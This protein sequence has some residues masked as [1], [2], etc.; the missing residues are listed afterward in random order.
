MFGNEARRAVNTAAERG[1]SRPPSPIA[2]VPRAP[3]ARRKLRLMDN[4]P[5][6]T[7]RDNFLGDGVPVRCTLRDKGKS[8]VRLSVV[9][10]L[11]LAAAPLRA[12]TVYRCVEKGKPVSF[13]S[14]PCDEKA[15]ATAPSATSRT[16][17]RH[18][19]RVASRRHAERNGPALRPGASG[20]GARGGSHASQCR[21]RD[22]LAGAQRA[23]RMGT[24]LPVGTQRR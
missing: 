3:Q 2:A 18:R 12:G 6:S 13:Q 19:R 14:E 20:D 15:R 21:R 24:P 7:P 8:M 1:R 4:A 9:A 16:P 11:L 17:N 10:A 22:V 23:R 5:G